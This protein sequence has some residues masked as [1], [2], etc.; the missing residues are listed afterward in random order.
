MLKL[1]LISIFPYLSIKCIYNYKRNNMKTIYK[2]FFEPVKFYGVKSEKDYDAIKSCLVTL[3][4][5]ARILP[6]S[7]YIIDYYKQNFLYISPNRLFLNNTSIEEIK[8]LGYLYYNRL[9]PLEDRK[10]LEFINKEGFDFYYK[11]PEEGRA[12][13]SIS[14]DFFIF[15]GPNKRKVLVNQKL[16]PILLNNKNQIWLALCTLSISPHK[17]QRGVIIRKAGAD[18]HYTYD[19][20]N[21]K[22][23][24]V[25]IPKLKDIDIDILKLSEQGL[26]NQEIADILFYDINSI[27]FHKKQIFNL[28]NV[29]NI[30]EAIDYAYNNKLI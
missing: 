7:M 18:S 26:S 23:Q 27:K 4:A 11:L 24:H 20:C 21:K 16:T 6:Y 25:N 19:F 2:Q 10:F 22:W 5:V 29:K 1:C 9:L 30:K 3:D 17:K 13:Y 8:N 12:N 28:L 14:Y 15:S